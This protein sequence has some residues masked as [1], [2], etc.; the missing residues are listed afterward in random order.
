MSRGDRAVAVFGQ[1]REWVAKK[2]QM[3][4][5]MSESLRDRVTPSLPDLTGPITASV[6]RRAGRESRWTR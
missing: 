3:M 2:S 1:G 4:V 6:A 5:L